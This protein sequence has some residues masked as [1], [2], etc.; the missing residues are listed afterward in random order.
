MKMRKEYENPII[1]IVIFSNEDVITTSPTG[2]E[3]QEDYENIPS[4]K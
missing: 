4:G 1:E 2:N 3:L